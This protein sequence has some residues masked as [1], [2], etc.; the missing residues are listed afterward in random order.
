MDNRN[1]ILAVVLSAVIL[2]GFQYYMELMYPKPPVD[3]NQQTAE[4]T[5]PGAPPASGGAQAP[6]AQA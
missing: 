1:M 4:Q 6:N 3:P 5:A 2:F